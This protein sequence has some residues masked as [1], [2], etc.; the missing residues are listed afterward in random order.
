M[1]SVTDW[2]YILD[3]KILERLGSTQREPPG[4]EKTHTWLAQRCWVENW[5]RSHGKTGTGLHGKAFS[6]PGEF[7]R[8]GWFQRQNVLTDL[9]ANCQLIGLPPP[10][11]VQIL[12]IA[13]K[14]YSLQIFFLFPFSFFK[15]FFFNLWPTES[16]KKWNVLFIRSP[17]VSESVLNSFCLD[18]LRCID[19]G[20]VWQRYNWNGPVSVTLPMKVSENTSRGVKIPFV[21]NIILPLRI[22]HFNTKKSRF[23]CLFTYV[24]Q[25]KRGM[26]IFKLP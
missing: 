26:L 6:S 13:P 18:G 8:W 22:I 19:K 24:H 21:T 1:F 17:D 14:F 23:I 9:L 2:K 10:T 4:S 12:F 20:S 3:I 7:I 5:R 15:T 11:N 16:H 25:N